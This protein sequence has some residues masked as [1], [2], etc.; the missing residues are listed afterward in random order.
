MLS[1]LLL[2]IIIFYSV[3]VDKNKYSKVEYFTR[4]S[5][6]VK[7]STTVFTTVQDIFKVNNVC[8]LRIRTIIH[9]CCNPISALYR[10]NR[11]QIKT[12]E[13]LQVL[14]KNVTHYTQ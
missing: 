1:L 7:V 13:L 5:L 11:E 9:N 2:C 8:T 6:Q 14:I 4:K 3:T 10:R 12:Q